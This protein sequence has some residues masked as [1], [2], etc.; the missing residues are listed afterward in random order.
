MHLSIFPLASSDW[1]IA[2]FRTDSS[3]FIALGILI[4][5]PIQLLK[6]KAGFKNIW[7]SRKAI[8]HR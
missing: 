3:A 8:S 4:S 2:R 1:G 6:D 5:L 7:T